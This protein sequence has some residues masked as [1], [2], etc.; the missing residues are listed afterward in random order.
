MI[1]LGFEPRL[2]DA[3]AHENSRPGQNISHTLITMVLGKKKPLRLLCIMISF[4]LYSFIQH[5]STL[6]EHLLCARSWKHRCGITLSKIKGTIFFL[7]ISPLGPFSVEVTHCHTL[8][9]TRDSP[10]SCGS[11][12][13]C[14]LAQ[15]PHCPCPGSVA[16]SLAGLHNC[17]F[18]A[19]SSSSSRLCFTW[20]PEPSS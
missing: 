12:H 7:Q 11:S 5:H 19:L 10:R 20:L 15:K 1:R 18:P 14:S 4:F 9:N 6:T 8:L 13:V 3:R 16:S 17:H 2:S